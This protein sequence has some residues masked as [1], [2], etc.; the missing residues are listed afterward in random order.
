LH[1]CHW[2]IAGLCG[3]KTAPFPFGEMKMKIRI[4]LSVCALVLGLAWVSLPSSNGASTVG[5]LWQ[6]SRAS[7]AALFAPAPTGA[8][9]CGVVSAYTPA[10]TVAGSIKIG[11]LNF[12]IAPGASL[13]G[14]VVGQDSC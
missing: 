10:T 13:K 7:A 1:N 11:G 3:S 14:V 6:F 4:T 9:V 8:K 2:T 5:R 12:T